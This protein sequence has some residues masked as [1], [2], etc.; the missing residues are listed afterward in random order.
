VETS[1]VDT[2]CAFLIVVAAAGAEIAGVLAMLF[3]AH[4]RRIALAAN[5]EKGSFLP[6]WS[7]R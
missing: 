6:G 2:I 7:W 5:R 4:L 1:K 3:L